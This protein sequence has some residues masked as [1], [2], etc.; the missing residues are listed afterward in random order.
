MK[1]KVTSE[2][3][4]FTCASGNLLYIVTCNGCGENYI[5]QTG[6]KLR[7]RFTVHRQQIR[8]PSVRKISLSEHLE[9]CANT[10]NYSIFPFYQCHDE[11][12]EAERI[13]K[14]TFFIRKYKPKNN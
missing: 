10:N 4:N 13:N 1:V 12:T 6:T 5:G 7:T 14:E 3:N 11:C 9:E 8:D 2:R